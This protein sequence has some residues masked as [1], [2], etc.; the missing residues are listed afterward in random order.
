MLDIQ[1]IWTDA[2]LLSRNPSDKGSVWAGVYVGQGGNVLMTKKGHLLCNQTLPSIT[3]HVAELYAIIRAL[4]SVPSE[5]TG[6]VYSDNE[7]AIG[8]Y[9]QTYKVNALPALVLREM[10]TSRN[11]LFN[12]P[13]I[14]FAVCKSNPT[15]KELMYKRALDGTDMPV[16]IYN[17]MADK[18]CKHHAEYVKL[19]EI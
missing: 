7:T 18:I 10:L 13:K 4:D 15:Q 6:E 14:E 11:R 2:G 12:F 5:W 9:F 17:K 16:S 19:F 8:W 3:S 1:S